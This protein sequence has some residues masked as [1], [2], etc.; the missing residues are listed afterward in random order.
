MRSA[1]GMTRGSWVTTST[2]QDRSWAARLKISITCLPCSQSRALVGSSAKTRVGLLDEGPPDGD[3]LL[4]PAGQLPGEQVRFA[5]QVQQP[6]QSPGAP[7]GL[8]RGEPLAPAQ[9]HLQLL[10]HG[11]GREQVKAL[12]DEAHVLPAKLAP[13]RGG[14]GVEVAT[15][16]QDLAAGRRQQSG[17][18]GQ[19]SRLAAA[20]RSHGQGQLSRCQ[21][22]G[23]VAQALG[24]PGPPLPKTCTS[25]RPERER[26]IH[27]GTRFRSTEQLGRFEVAQRPQGRQTGE[28]GDSQRQGEGERQD[29]GG[30]D[31]LRLQR[32]APPG[33]G[34]R[35]GQRQERPAHAQPKR[36]VQHQTHR[37]SAAESRA[38]PARRIPSTGRA[39]RR[40][41]S[42]W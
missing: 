42:H 26:L 15:A 9:H 32:D 13:L 25:R 16:D 24:S 28:D 33:P 4:F 7:G 29:R 21:I 40:K 37:V 38:R 8:V 14:Q 2:V 35:S 19:Q 10:A 6:E 18:Y 12:K 41:A 11:E 1:N 17:Q 22:E 36:L 5:R 20:G 31:H 30:E 23:N 39:R 27:G 3:A 34:P